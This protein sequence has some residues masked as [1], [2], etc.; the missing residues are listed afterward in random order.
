[1][2]SSNNIKKNEKEIPKKRPISSISVS[3]EESDNNYDR[4]ESDFM[5]PPDSP[6]KQEEEKKQSKTAS[7]REWK[8]MINSLKLNSLLKQKVL[9][10]Q[11]RNE[12][13]NQINS[14]KSYNDNDIILVNFSGYMKYTYMTVAN[15]FCIARGLMLALPKYE[16]ID[17]RLYCSR[18]KK[19]TIRI[20]EAFCI[21]EKIMMDQKKEKKKNL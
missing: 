1:M 15:A 2:S 20:V 4:M 6:P 10:C 18:N 19:K 16:A 21:K 11:W 9:A 14:N 7:N 3:E 13:S 5:N 8:K 12:L 17:T